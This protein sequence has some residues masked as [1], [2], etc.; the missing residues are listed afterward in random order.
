MTV[1]NQ[2]LEFLFQLHADSFLK[3]KFKTVTPTYF[4]S[5]IFLIISMIERKKKRC[6]PPS[7]SL[8][9]PDEVKLCMSSV[10]GAEYGVYAAQPIPP[11]TWI[12]PYE[13]QVIRRDE[14]RD[15]AHNN[16]MWEVRKYSS[17]GVHS[18]GR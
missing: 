6:S 4:E 7:P 10:P 17:S 8:V 9:F 3:P 15:G 13:G 16:Y 1:C 5:L 12:G 2:K 18:Y 11:G 14:L